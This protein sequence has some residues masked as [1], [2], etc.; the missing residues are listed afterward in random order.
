[1]FYIAKPFRV[2]H[3][4]APSRKK[5]VMR[6]TCTLALTCLLAACAPPKAVEVPEEPTVKPK[7][8]KPAP[9]QEASAEPLRM[10]QT[11]G[12]KTPDLAQ[13]LPDSKDMRPT[14]EPAKQDGPTVRAK[15]PGT[16]E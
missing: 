7:N 12:M 2:L 13:K 11:G 6:L 3:R 1:M 15:A 14:T 5:P 16:T 10:V 9:V 8:T 4:P